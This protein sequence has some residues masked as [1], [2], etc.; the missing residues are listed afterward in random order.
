MA[1]K[2]ITNFLSEEYKDFSLYV[3]ENRA[4]PSVIDGLKP[5]QRKII[6][7]SD[8]VWK[9]GN[10]K[11]LKVFQLSG[12][13]AS[14]A[15]YH[16]GDCLSPE[17]EIMLDDGSIITISKWYEEYPEKQFR[18]LSYDEK[19]LK[20]THGIGHSP[21]IGQITNIEYEIEMEDGCIFLCTENHPFLTNRGWV[22]AKD[23]T[24]DDEIKSFNDYHGG[25][26]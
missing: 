16:H 10:E 25:K 3:I 22:Q 8:K 15:F 5:V 20:F 24:D 2:T 9:T 1:E 14:E 17:T 7:I 12:K 26:K 13:V 11:P 4:I 21:R 23:L 6:H 19:K 18:V